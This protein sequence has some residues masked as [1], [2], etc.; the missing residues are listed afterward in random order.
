MAGDIIK[1]IPQTELEIYGARNLKNGLIQLITRADGAT[2]V[3]VSKKH[4][5]PRFLKYLL[6]TD[7]ELLPACVQ[8]RLGNNATVAELSGGN[9][10]L[11]R[12]P[13]KPMCAAIS[14]KE[15]E[16]VLMFKKRQRG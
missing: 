3:Y 14:K 2:S 4:L 1:N 9:N 5:A 13:I 7:L 12:Q 8:A 15:V 11:Y 6:T 10:I 16:R